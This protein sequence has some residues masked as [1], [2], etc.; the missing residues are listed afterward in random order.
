MSDVQEHL[1][2]MLW[3]VGIEKITV[4]N[5]EKVWVRIRMWEDAVRCPRWNADADENRFTTVKEVSENV[6]VAAT[7]A[8]EELTDMQFERKLTHNVR[9]AAEKSYRTNS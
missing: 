2:K 3:T 8:T 5:I 4:R 7:E 9:A 6:G 1:A